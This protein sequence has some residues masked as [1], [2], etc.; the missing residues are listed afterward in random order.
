VVDAPAAAAVRHGNG[1]IGYLLMVVYLLVC[2]GL[3]VAVLSQTSK[4]EGLGGTLGGGGTQSV[5]HGKKSVEEKLGTITN[6][7]AV[8]FIVLSMVV[9]L[10]L[11]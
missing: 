9:S 11:R 3:I 8:S 5:F 2:L 1:V 6:V 7:L 10:A 4:N